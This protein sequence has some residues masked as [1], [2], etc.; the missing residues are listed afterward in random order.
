MAVASVVAM[1]VAVAVVVSVSVS[2]SMSLS[3]SVPDCVGVCGFGCGC[4]TCTSGGTVGPLGGR[5]R[6][7]GG[8][9]FAAPQATPMILPAIVGPLRDFKIHTELC[10]VASWRP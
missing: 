8:S 3:V 9:E 2:V 10:N 5:K 1:S 7:S 6:T 4:R